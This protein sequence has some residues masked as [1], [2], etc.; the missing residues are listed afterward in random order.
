M[1]LGSAAYKKNVE[2][3]S[4]F[5]LRAAL[6]QPSEGT[7]CALNC[8][9]L[10]VLLVTYAPLAFIPFHPFRRKNAELGKKIYGDVL[11]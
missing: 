2:G 6:R 9:D 10:N 11:N 4:A 1:M 5:L 7:F 8:T 3:G